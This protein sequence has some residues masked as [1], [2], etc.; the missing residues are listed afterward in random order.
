MPF[1]SASEWTSQ[2]R[3][4]VCGSTGPTGP[5]GPPG[6]PTGPTGSSTTGS[7]GPTGL[8][9]ATGPTGLAG[10]TGPLGPTGTNGTNGVDGATGSTGS[11]G[12][13][14]TGIKPPDSTP[15]VSQGYQ[16]IGNVIYQWGEVLAGSPSGSVTF[17]VPY[18]SV[19]GESPSVIIQPI[20]GSGAV[21]FVAN[22]T[23]TAFNFSSG[24]IPIAVIKWF[25]VGFAF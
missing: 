22:I 17:H 4:I 23:N 18:R 2:A 3:S 7:T 5:V 12:P 15:Y 11:T 16:Q 9:G 1:F 19:P 21:P 10:A 6:G 14:P 25:S 8:A 13:S 20:A 24:Q